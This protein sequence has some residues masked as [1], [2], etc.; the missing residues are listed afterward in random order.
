MPVIVNS[1]AIHPFLPSLGTPLAIESARAAM[2]DIRPLEIA[3]INLMADKQTTERQLA[4]W[5]GNT[6]LQVRL[7]FATTDGYVRDVQGGRE[8]R[9]TP[10]EHIRRFYSGWGEIKDR[11]FDGLVVT[12]VNALKERVSDEA[13]WPEV[14]QI[15]RW[16]E[17][18]VLS[19]L[20]LC[21]GA[22]A[23]LKHFH[24]VESYKGRQKLFGLF[25]HRLVTDKTGLLFGFPDLFQVPVSRWKSPRREDI[26]KH[27]AL[28]IVADSDESGPNIMVESTAPDA[29]K[30]AFARRVYILNHPEYDTDTLGAEYRRDAAANPDQPLP[31]HYFP[32]DDPTRPPRNTRRHSAHIYTNWIKALY[33]A[34]PYNL[35]DIAPSP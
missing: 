2:Q 17:T 27:P 1:N 4:L 3:I 35:E 23:A 26:L 24:D 12:G 9:N 15:L 22:K 18:N 29:G 21:W 6:M 14:Q 25:D 32:G 13:I 28:E 30:P 10:S 20:F 7:T 8:S 11:R 19:S 34:T 16:S 5:L 31:L 33:E